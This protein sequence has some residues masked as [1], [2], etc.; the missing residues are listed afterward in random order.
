[1]SGATIRFK[2]CSLQELDAQAQAGGLKVGEPYFIADTGQLA[3]GFSA[4]SYRMVS[5]TGWDDLVA[6]V[7]RRDMPAQ[8]TAGFTAASHDAGTVSSGSLLLDPASGNFWHYNNGGAHTLV[9]P[10][11]PCTMIIEVTNTEAASPPELQG[12]T[13]EASGDEFD[14]AVGAAHLAHVRVTQNHAVLSWEAMQ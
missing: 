11:M 5:V 8:L 14:T 6:N 10:T 7:L 9:A 1:M 12:F 4:T 13:R 2:R 3:I